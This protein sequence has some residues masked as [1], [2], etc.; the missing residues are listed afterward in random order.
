MTGMK[1][2]PQSWLVFMGC[3]L[4]IPHYRSMFGVVATC[5]V[6]DS[7]PLLTCVVVELHFIYPYLI[8]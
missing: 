6:P 7:K 5:F 4:G 3:L 8:T 1:T 2:A